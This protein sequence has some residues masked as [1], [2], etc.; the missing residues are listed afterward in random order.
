VAPLGDRATELCDDDRP[1]S[2]S[3]TPAAGG[4]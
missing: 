3:S 4:R 1:T 2:T